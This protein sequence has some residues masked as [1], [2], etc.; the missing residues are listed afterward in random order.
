M[1]YSVSIDCKGD[2]FLQHLFFEYLPSE[3][4]FHAK[5]GLIYIKRSK[6]FY[7]SIKINLVELFTLK[8]CS[9]LTAFFPP[10]IK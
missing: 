6:N 4:V 10:L 8:V 5:S 1:I 9:R 3:C 7:K 2:G